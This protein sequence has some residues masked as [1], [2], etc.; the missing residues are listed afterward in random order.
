[1][2]KLGLLPGRGCSTCYHLL[3]WD[4]S[5]IFWPIYIFVS[6]AYVYVTTL[7]SLLWMYECLTLPQNNG[8]TYDCYSP[9]EKRNTKYINKLW[10]N[11]N[12]QKLSWGARDISQG[13]KAVV[14]LVGSILKQPYGNSQL[15]ATSVPG[16]WYPLL[17]SVGT[18]H[19]CDIHTYIHTHARK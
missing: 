19:T 15:S 7:L 4:I 11:L 18:R 5:N 2:V 17:A 16:I 10:L 12:Y 14:F 6:N 9:W 1:M 13:F 8:I 3:F